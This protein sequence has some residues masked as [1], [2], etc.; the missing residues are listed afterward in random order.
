MVP[1]FVLL[2]VED[3]AGQKDYFN[4]EEKL[5]SSANYL[6]QCSEGAG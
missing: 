2:Q 4:R 3:A 1:V 5:I 6:Q